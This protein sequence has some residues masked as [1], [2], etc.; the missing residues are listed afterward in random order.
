MRTRFHSTRY[1][2]W[3]RPWDDRKRHRKCSRLGERNTKAGDAGGGGNDGA[4]TALSG[5]RTNSAGESHCY[6]C[7]K[8]GHWARECPHLSTKQ[9][10]QLH[11][12][13][14]R[15]VDEDQEVQMAH[16][17][18]HVSMLQADELPDNHAN[19]DGCF[20]VTAFEM[21]KYLENLRRVKQGVKISCNSG[22]MCTNIVG[23]YGNMTS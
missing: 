4:S 7:S 21:K 3:S 15:E 20:T 1:S 6:N 17:F 9:Q 14:E 13:L 2:R 19:L 5:T 16:Q 11:M 18:F 10:E 22:V 12:V 8:E 23:D